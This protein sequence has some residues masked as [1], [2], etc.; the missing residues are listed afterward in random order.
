MARRLETGACNVNDVLVNYLAY[1]VP[2]AGWKESGVGYRHGE[3][4]IKKYCRSESVVITRFGGKREPTWY[5]Y[6]RGRRGLVGRIAQ[7]F[8]A[9]DVKR[10]LGMRG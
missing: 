8:N 7:A 9:R 2:M 4:G 6:A 3:F 5:P 1:D 10:R